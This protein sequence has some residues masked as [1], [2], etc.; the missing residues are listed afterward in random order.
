MV[1][2]KQESHQMLLKLAAQS[3]RASP[4]GLCRAKCVTGSSPNLYPI[5]L[6]VPFT[7]NFI[8]FSLIMSL[9]PL[10]HRFYPI[11]TV[12]TWCTLIYRINGWAMRGNS[13][14]LFTTAWNSLLHSIKLELLFIGCH[15]VTVSIFLMYHNCKH[16]YQLLFSVIGFQTQYAV[17][18]KSFSKDL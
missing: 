14:V 15:F 1:I 17:Q 2:Y 4:P 3:V 10:L 11:K 18:D 6:P 5:L 16:L 12:G 8:I 13:C 9:I 7:L